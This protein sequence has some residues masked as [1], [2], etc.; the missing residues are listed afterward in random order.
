V[1]QYD[2]KC[3]W[4]F[5]YTKLL[6]T[7]ISLLVDHLLLLFIISFFYIACTV[8]C[9]SDSYFAASALSLFYPM[10]RACAQTSIIALHEQFAAFFAVRTRHHSHIGCHCAIALAF[11]TS[12]FAMLPCTL[13]LSRLCGTWCEYGIVCFSR[14]SLV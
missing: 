12:L 4:I 11:Q 13:D 8:C 1:S 3:A 14:F 2:G 9:P 5:A 10:A 7:V 6:Q